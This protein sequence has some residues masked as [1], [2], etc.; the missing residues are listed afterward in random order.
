[1][2]NSAL[3]RAVSAGVVLAAV[4]LLLGNGTIHSTFALF[5]GQTTNANSG[6]AGGWVGAP[7]AA[8]AT[9][10]GYDMSLAW[11]PGTHGPVTGQQ[12][13]GVDNL[14]NSNCTG[15]AYSSLATMATA[16]TATYIDASRGTPANNGNWF[17][18][19]LKSTSATSWTSSLALPAVQLGL[20]T[21]GVQITNVGTANRIEKNDTIT[22]TFNQRTNVGTSNIKVCVYTSGVIL[23][24]DTSTNCASASSGYTVGKLT[25]SGVTIPTALNF[26]SSG[27]TRTTVAPWTMTITLAG[28]NSTATMSAGTPSW[29]LTGSS[30]I[31]SFATTHQATMCSAVATTCQPTTSTNF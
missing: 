7:T 28:T 24:G 18:Y 31:L 17:C 23:L 2:R 14:T 26:N 21:T 16:A 4:A 6:F 11:T 19:Q 8:T 1:V 12:L 25:L 30:S 5:N 3:R 9:A 22:L 15:A 13:F 10:S 27:V 20:V 29:K